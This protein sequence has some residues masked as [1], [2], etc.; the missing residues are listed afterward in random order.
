MKV[1]QAGTGRT[2]I[3]ILYLYIKFI[4]CLK[5]LFLTN[6]QYIL[7]NLVN[8]P[9]FIDRIEKIDNQIQLLL[10]KFDSFE[11]QIKDMKDDIANDGNK[12]L[13]DKR[14]E[15]SDLEKE[16]GDLKG[17]VKDQDKLLGDIEAKIAAL[18]RQIEND[19]NK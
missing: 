7:L 18:K 11:K 12:Q 14:G 15:L 2:H 5:L 19:Q 6:H 9:K 16:L 3:N 13:S 8:K 17:K 1:S 10:E 4:Y